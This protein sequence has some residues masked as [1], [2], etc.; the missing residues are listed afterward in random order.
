MIS[1]NKPVSSGIKE[2][3][4]VLTLFH[5]N[6]QSL[7]NKI[8]ELEVLLTEISPA[9]FCVTEHWLKYDDVTRVNFANYKLV[10][11]SAR[12]EFRGGG[13]AIFIKNCSET[14]NIN[15]DI[16]QSEKN[17]E[18]S[19]AELKIGHQRYKIMCVYRSPIGDFDMFLTKLNQALDLMYSPGSYLI[20]SGDFNVDF[21]VQNDRTRSILQLLRSF[22]LKPHVRG[23]TRVSSVSST[24]V[25]NIF[26]NFIESDV[27]CLVHVS[28]VSDHYGQILQFKAP[29]ELN[30]MI[31]IKRRY[32]NEN[33]ISNFVSNLRMETWHHLD[34]KTGVDGKYDAFFRVLYYHFDVSFPLCITRLRERNNS[35]VSTEI[36]SYAGYIKDLYVW[37]KRSGSTQAYEFYK[38]ERQKYRRFLS[39]HRKGL[40][41]DKILNSKNKSK[42]AWSIFNTET[43]RKKTNKTI[44]LEDAGVLVEDP[45]ELAQ[46]F[47][48]HFSLPF[49][50]HGDR[51]FQVNSGIPTIFLNPVDRHEVLDI[52]LSLQN[53]YSSGLDE[54]PTCA[55]KW[56]AD[57][58]AEPL[59]NIINESFASGIFPSALKAAKLIPVPKRGNTRDI[60]DYRPISLLSAISKVFERAIYN[61][62]MKFLDQHHVLSENQ[63]GFRVKRSTELAIF[64]VITYII[65][66]VDKNEKVA[67]LYFDL[68]K[69]FDTISHH[70]ML[71]RLGGY[72]IRGRCSELLASYLTGRKQW[73]CIEKDG[74]RY[75]SAPTELRRGVPQG[76]ILGPLLFL[77]YVNGLGDR[78][79]AG[80]LCQF[81]DDTSVVM[82]SP[83]VGGL[84]R[85][86]SG[87]VE[88]M[89]DWCNENMLAL[90]ANKTGL[91]VFTKTIQRESL[92]VTLNRKTVPAVEKVKFLGVNIDPLLKWEHH[93]T[94]L[95]SRLSSNCALIRRLRDTVTTE[96]LRV[97]YF[98]CIQ[99]IINYGIIFWGSSVCASRILR[100]QKRIIRS[101]CHL[102]PRTS[103]RPYFSNLNILTAPSL[104]FLALVVFVRKNPTLFDTNFENYSTEMS[105]VT[106]NR[107]NLCIPTHNSTYYKRGPHYRAIKAYESLPRN[108]QQI[109]SF[110]KFKSEVTA[111]LHSKCF[112]SF[113]FGS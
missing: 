76:S 38:T 36:K 30:R 47:S 64:K 80:M 15:L 59:A 74:R 18:V 65:E 90:N 24:Q 16:A 81:A 1:T 96:A 41:D 49:E 43:N 105:L 37:Y 29:L 39:N 13:T 23:M 70:L 56:V 97:Y 83:T 34:D 104:Y 8:L 9:I 26:S 75:Y 87:A 22:D 93:I 31:N 95:E 113:D 19:V 109:D 52:I 10:G 55:I 42:T 45:G 86:C 5:L 4:T 92:Y 106:R 110:K 72:G 69:A 6:A 27:T 77:L 85:G 54:I 51:N 12:N 50:P 84:S 71:E 33:N 111:Y 46:L 89:S 101:M 7:N 79:P 73:V 32:F 3:D 14:R 21:S 20:L 17:F 98:A 82:A 67:G 48:R 58:L 88:W 68:S 63:Y 94:S 28:D 91:M 57:L 40:Y 78:F 62:I 61:R 108:L 100:V 60:A 66:N 44:T 25:D 112:Y 35:W 107:A 102:H 103:C 53:K 2:A 99:S 11:Y